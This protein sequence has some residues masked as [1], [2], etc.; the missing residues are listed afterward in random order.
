MP[1][2]APAVKRDAVAGYD[3]E[4]TFCEP[5][6]DAREEG[7]REVRER[8]GASFIHPFNDYRVIAGQ[9]TAALEFLEDVP[10]LDVIMAPV[11]GGGLMSGTAIA[12]AALSPGIRIFGA[13]PAMADDALRSLRAGEIIPST[14]PETV[15]DGLRT[16]LG[17][18]TFPILRKHL[19]DILLAGEDEIIAAMRDVWERMKLVVEPSAAVPLAALKAAGE[20]LRGRKVG[21]IFSGGNV[22]LSSLPW[23]R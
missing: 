15:A 22:E 14:Y 18:L 4:I 17:D 23:C 10:D 2:N 5:T 8:T 19:E 16:S 6:L 7:L 11:G 13:E 1:R 3:A 21:I 9:G 20:R 12:A